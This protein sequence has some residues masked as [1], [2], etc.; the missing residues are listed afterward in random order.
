M[1]LTSSGPLTSSLLGLRTI[2]AESADFQEFV[3]AADAAAAEAKVH[4][5]DYEA[6]PEDLAAERPMATIWLADAFS[7]EA[8]AWGDRAMLDPGGD[9]VLEIQSGDEAA[10]DREAGYWAFVTWMDKIITALRDRA[11]VN[12]YL[13]IRAIRQLYAPR[14]SPPE[15]DPSTSGYWHCALVVSWG[16]GGNS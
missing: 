11:A 10:A 8:I 2:L 3:G 12:D 5:F 16:R 6:E 7:M 13:T 15:D 1:P 4:L 14:R 9:L